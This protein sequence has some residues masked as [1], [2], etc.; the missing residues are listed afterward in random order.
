MRP[1]NTY[2]CAEGTWV[3]I[4]S[5]SD[6]LFA[7]LCRAIGRPELA[8]DPMF[9][10]NDARS[11]NRVRL[12]A[13][14]AAWVG[15]RTF[16]EVEARMIEASIPASKIFS[17]KDCVDDPHYRMRGS[18]IEV[19]SRNG[20]AVKQPNIFPFF[21]GEDAPAVRWPGPALG[22]HNG[23]IFQGLLGLGEDDL[24]RLRAEAAI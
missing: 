2:R 20:T 24:R 9:S 14:I 12:D 23:E 8:D 4:T 1:S 13:I 22:E 19:S 7:R 16:A 10:T 17:I 6:R 5:T 15:A 11:A 18:I 21:S 3:C